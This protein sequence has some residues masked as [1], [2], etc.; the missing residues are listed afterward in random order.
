MQRKCKM[1]VIGFGQ[2]GYSY[3]HMIMSNPAAELTA[4]CEASRDRADSFARELD[5][6]NIPIFHSVDELIA[7]S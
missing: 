4:V 6:K 1:A 2:R 7:K 5:L 3:A